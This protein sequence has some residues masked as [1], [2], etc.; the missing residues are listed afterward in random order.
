MIRKSMRNKELYSERISQTESPIFF[1]GWWLDSVAG[2]DDWDAFVYEHKGELVAGL[3][4]YIPNKNPK[5]VAMPSL[6]QFLGPVFFDSSSYGNSGPALEIQHKAMR[7][8]AKEMEDND[9]VIL[10]MDPRLINWLPFS[11]AGY[12]QSTRYTYKIPLESM[13][14]FSDRY[15]K[16]LRKRLSAAKGELTVGGVEPKEFFDLAV[17]MY[18]AKGLSVPY[19]A[20]VIERVFS[21]IQKRN[22]GFIVSVN[23]DSG[24]IVGV[25]VFVEDEKTVYYLLSVTDPGLRDYESS[26]A[27]LNKAIGIAKEKGKE[28]DFEGSMNEGIE[29]YF[30]MFGAVQVPYLE[31]KKDR[32]SLISKISNLF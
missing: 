17:K 5:G 32:R 3:P 8:F 22:S 27:I 6:T 4:Y 1:K 14:D 30:R 10:R 23:D 26:A 29:Q 21:S 25:G 20:D 11:W 28:F 19:G 12:S 2:S 7:S 18:S 31:V 24:K 16:N 9:H 13:S 15:S